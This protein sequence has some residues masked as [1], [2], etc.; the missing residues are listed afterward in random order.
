MDPKF[1]LERWQKNEIGFHAAD[2]Q[3]ALVKHWPSLGVAQG[4]RVLVPLCG[5]TLDM[6][7]IE[8]QGLNV[9]G[10]ELSAV[11]VRDFFAERNLTPKPRE[12]PGFE[13]STAGPCEIWCGDFFALK[14]ND[15][16]S[17]AA[18]DRAAL[19]A[20]PPQMQPRYAAKMAEL[21]PKGAKVLL[22]GLDYDPQEMQGPPFN[23]PQARVR[24]LFE[25]DFSVSFLDA[26]DSLAKTDH[27]KKRG[28]TRLEEATYLLVRK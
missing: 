20:M 25:K 21:M 28:I 16:N 12:A 14:K 8:E 24:E 22:V 11:A 23:I 18:Y 3:P 9:V 4:A 1:W 26:R 19:V 6:V 10:S 5:K 2:V 17:T 13:V 15:V 7:W 27:L